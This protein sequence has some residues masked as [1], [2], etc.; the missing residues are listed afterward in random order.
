MLDLNEIY[1]QVLF[2]SLGPLAELKSASLIAAG[3]HNQGIRLDSNEG[4][5]FLKLNFDHEKD[6]L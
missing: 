6:I 3:S 4:S 5:F 2:D 1:E